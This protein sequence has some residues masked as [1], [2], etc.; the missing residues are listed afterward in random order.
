MATGVLCSTNMDMQLRVG[1]GSAAALPYFFFYFSKRAGFWCLTCGSSGLHRASISRAP[2]SLHTEHAG[3]SSLITIA[4]GHPT[5]VAFRGL[6]THAR[7]NTDH[8]SNRPVSTVLSRRGTTFLGA[9]STVH[10]HVRARLPSHN[11]VKPHHRPIIT[12][13]RNTLMSTQSTRAATDT[14][15]NSTRVVAEHVC[16]KTPNICLKV[17]EIDTKQVWWDSH[18]HSVKCRSTTQKHS[19][20]VFRSNYTHTFQK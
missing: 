2:G 17:S 10:K 4:A 3:L 15:A 9:C 11:A 20:L 6:A 13:W 1:T 8:E 12:R 19:A 14:A 18:P 16:H 5:V 7:A